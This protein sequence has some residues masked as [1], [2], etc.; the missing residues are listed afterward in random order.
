MFDLE[1]LCDGVFQIMQ[2][3]D[4]LNAKIAAIE[5]EKTAKGKG[6][7]PA[8]AAIPLTS[9]YFQ[10]WSEK[11][12]QN[13]PAIWYGIEKVDT[14][15]GGQ[16]AT[17]ERTTIFVEVILVD[18]G[19]TNDVSKRILRY[20]RALKE[21]F[22][23]AFSV[24]DTGAKIKIETVRPESFKFESDSSDEIKIGGVSLSIT[25]A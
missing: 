21:L 8:L 3:G 9:Y 12:L 10:S 22:S 19:Q 5:V 14:T 2:D 17:A 20:S 6:L 25:L 16:G 13:N 15:D 24:A 1:D 7:S 4:A 18:N 23:D 11:M